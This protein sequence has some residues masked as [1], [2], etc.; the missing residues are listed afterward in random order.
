MKPGI[1]RSKLKDDETAEATAFLENNVGENFT[2]EIDLM[3][4]AMRD[5]LRKMNIEDLIGKKEE[6][7]VA[8]E[9]LCSREL[10]YCYF[11]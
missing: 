2:H 10:I 5:D 1:V 11:N 4:R 8:L 6:S 9:F 3:R 7:E